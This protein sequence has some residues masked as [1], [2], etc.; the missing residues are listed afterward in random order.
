MSAENDD[1]MSKDDMKPTLAAWAGLCALFAGGVGVMSLASAL[2]WGMNGSFACDADNCVEDRRGWIAAHYGVWL[3]FVGLLV[4]CAGLLV[5]NYTQR[6]R[7]A[8]AART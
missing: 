6:R 7:A 2:K 5:A 1:V 8:R 3:L 4:L